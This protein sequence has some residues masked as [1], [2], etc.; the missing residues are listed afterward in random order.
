LPAVPRFTASVD[1]AFPPEELPPEV[2][3]PCAVL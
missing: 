1:A 2:F 3:P